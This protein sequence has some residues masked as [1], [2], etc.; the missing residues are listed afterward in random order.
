MPKKFKQTA[1]PTV[2]KK[3]SCSQL[4]LCNNVRFVTITSISIPP[5]VKNNTLINDEEAYMMIL[6]IQGL[7]EGF[8]VSQ[9]Y[10]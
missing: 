4:G 9:F 1:P 6:E 2:Y 7:V 8:M 3:A 10:A 5:P